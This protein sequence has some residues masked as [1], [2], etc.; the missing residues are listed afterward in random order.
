MNGN[1]LE[2]HGLPVPQEEHCLGLGVYHVFLLCSLFLL[3][4]WGIPF[5]MQFPVGCYPF[6]SMTFCIS[7]TKR[8]RM[9]GAMYLGFCCFGG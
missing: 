8:K 9:A 2:I 3:L 4:Y 1:C 5:F 7:W 6:N